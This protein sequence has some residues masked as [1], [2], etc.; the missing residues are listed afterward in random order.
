MKVMELAEIAKLTSIIKEW[1]ISAFI[2]DWKP[3]IGVKQKNM[4]DRFDIRQD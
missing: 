4:I 1:A 3:I 2:G